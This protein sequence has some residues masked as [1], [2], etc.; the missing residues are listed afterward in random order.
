MATASKAPATPATPAAAIVVV[1][2]PGFK[3]AV[4]KDAVRHVLT[5]SGLEFS[6]KTRWGLTGPAPVYI[7]NFDL[8]LEGTIDPFLKAG[9][10]INIAEY[11]YEITGG[12]RADHVAAW[13]QFRA[14]FAFSLSQPEGTVVVD[15]ATEAW[16]LCRLARLGKLS[17]VQPFHY[18]PVNSEV[19]ELVRSAYGST[20][21]TVFTQKL[22]PVYLDDK[23][24]RDYE[25]KGFN[26]MPYLAQ[27]NLRAWREDTADGPLWHITVTKCRQRPDL[28]GQ[29]LVDLDVDLDA[30]LEQ[31][32]K[33]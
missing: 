21:T 7:H 31:V 4:L 33:D 17:N 16:E 10:D 24:T 18:G 15:T 30:F 12:N 22:A 19:R 1:R 8:G 23:R 25:A 32:C 27:S 28:V 3:K 26:D 6:G 13:E 5:I 9:K 29:D 11:P 14:D 2:K 20:M